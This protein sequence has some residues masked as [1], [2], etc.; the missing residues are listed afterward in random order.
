MRGC[1]KHEPD[2]LLKP[3]RGSLK[4]EQD[5]LVKPMRGSLKQDR[6]LGLGRSGEVLVILKESKAQ[7]IA[8]RTI[9]NICA[10]S[11]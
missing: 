8:L 7:A 4:H 5:W 3:M 1:L 10:R 6:G 2:W 11:T 9:A